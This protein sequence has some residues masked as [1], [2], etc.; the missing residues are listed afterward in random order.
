MRRKTAEELSELKVR[1]SGLS[2]DGARESRDAIVIFEKSISRRR[3]GG[4]DKKKKRMS[5]G[6]PLLVQSKLQNQDVAVVGC[7]RRVCAF[8]ALALQFGDK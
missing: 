8:L 1:A 2:D 3:R 4:R 5:G 7:R 6:R